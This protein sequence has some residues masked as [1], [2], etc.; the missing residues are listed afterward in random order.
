LVL[1]SLIYLTSGAWLSASISVLDSNADFVLVRVGLV[2]N[3]RMDLGKRVVDILVPDDVVIAQCRGD[4]SSHP[5][6]REIAHTS[7]SI[8]DGEH[9]SSYWQEAHDFIQ[10]SCLIHLRLQTSRR[11]IPIQ[12]HIGNQ[13]RRLTIERGNTAS[14]YEVEFANVRPFVS[15]SLNTISLKARE[16]ARSLKRKAN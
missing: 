14:V 2:N 12:L 1:V 7:E 15:R 10:G 6:P 8:D 9:Q 3:G 13:K 11:S 16:L 5:N 4:G